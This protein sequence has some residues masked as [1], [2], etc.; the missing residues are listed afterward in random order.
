M[1]STLTKPT[2]N[3][4]PVVLTCP[5]CGRRVIVHVPARVS[6][7]PCGERM[8]PLAPPEPAAGPQ[9]PEEGEP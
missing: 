6:C 3:P 1:T 8:H 2:D 7:L 5:A 9:Q 4:R